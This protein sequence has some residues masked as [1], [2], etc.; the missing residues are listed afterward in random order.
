M[1]LDFL[2]FIALFVTGFLVFSLFAIAMREWVKI[3]KFNRDSYAPGLTPQQKIQFDYRM[4][5]MARALTVISLG[6][7][8]KGAIRRLIF[9]AFI[10]ALIFGFRTYWAD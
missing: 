8:Y 2:L 4:E 9:F 6:Q 10:L 5:L 1:T 3:M 7:S